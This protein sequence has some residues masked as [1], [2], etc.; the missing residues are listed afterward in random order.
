MLKG[1]NNLFNVLIKAQIKYR[2]FSSRKKAKETC[3]NN[4]S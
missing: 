4:R 1:K 2:E 3:Y